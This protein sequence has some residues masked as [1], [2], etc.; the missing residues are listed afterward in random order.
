MGSAFGLEARHLQEIAAEW[1]MTRGGIEHMPCGLLLIIDSL[2][3][4]ACGH[5]LTG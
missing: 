2:A 3:N 5:P 1:H 4:P